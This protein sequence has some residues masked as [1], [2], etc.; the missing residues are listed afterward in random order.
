MNND[1]NAVKCALNHVHTPE[2]QRKAQEAAESKNIMKELFNTSKYMSGAD[3][4]TRYSEYLNR[5]LMRDADSHVHN[6]YKAFLDCQETDR[7]ELSFYERM[8]IDEMLRKRH[9]DAEE[10]SAPVTAEPETATIPPSSSHGPA[11]LRSRQGTAQET[12]RAALLSRTKS[13]SISRK[14]A[15]RSRMRSRLSG[16]SSRS[17]KQVMSEMRS[18]A[19]GEDAITRTLSEDEQEVMRAKHE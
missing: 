13:R 10:A 11:G 3:M 1:A 4:M 2:C 18:I 14:S 15:V 12:N 8:K 5:S 16:A 7:A 6:A 9:A 19:D 17:K